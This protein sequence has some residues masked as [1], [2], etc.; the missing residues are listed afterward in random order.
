[1]SAHYPARWPLDGALPPLANPSHSLSILS[2]SYLIF[3][4]FDKT[5]YVWIFAINEI[6][7][8][9][10]LRELS[11]FLVVTNMS[12]GASIAMS[13]IFVLDFVSSI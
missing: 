3:V 5:A 12:Y 2:T 8:Y 6:L 11:A 9:L 4:N 13:L 7:R 10:S 1:M